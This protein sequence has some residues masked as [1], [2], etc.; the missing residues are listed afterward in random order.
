GAMLCGGCGTQSKSPTGE[1]KV[2]VAKPVRPADLK[3][4][5]ELLGA[6]EVIAI[7]AAGKPVP[8]DRV[9]KIRLAYVFSEM[10]TVYITRPDRPS[11]VATFTVDATANPKK[12]TIKLSPPVRAVYAVEG[13]KMRLCL[14]VDEN[15]NAGFP[16][17]LVSTAT[18]KTDLLTLER[19]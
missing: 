18:P 10:K 4:F 13:N 19:R 8:A 6:W 12:L 15:P 9:Q 16:T 5:K 17:G 1:P 2:I 3:D 7:E 14:M 11:S